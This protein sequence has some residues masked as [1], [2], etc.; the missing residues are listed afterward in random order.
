MV[1]HF[2]IVI[3]ILF[4]SNFPVGPIK[5]DCARANF[6]LC[7]NSSCKITGISNLCCYATCICNLMINLELKY[8]FD[9][10]PNLVS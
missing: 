7:G 5:R 4:C 9:L 1:R 2:I 3:K 6:M 8:I 10:I